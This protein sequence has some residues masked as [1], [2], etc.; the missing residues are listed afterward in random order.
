MKRPEQDYRLGQHS[1]TKMGEPG[2]TLHTDTGTLMPHAGH[3][4]GRNLIW[5]RLKLFKIAEPG[6]KWNLGEIP[7]G[8]SSMKYITNPDTG[9]RGDMTRRGREGG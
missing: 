7:K 2:F 4:R 3:G 9:K 1:L 5:E 8:E 6:Q